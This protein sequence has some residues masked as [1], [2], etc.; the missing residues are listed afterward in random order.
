MIKS[1]IRNFVHDKK[2]QAGYVVRD[3]KKAYGKYEKREN[4]KDKIAHR[5]YPVENK[6]FKREGIYKADSTT[7]KWA[8]ARLKR[9]NYTVQGITLTDKQ[10]GSYVILFSKRITRAAISTT[11]RAGTKTRK[12]RVY[13]AKPG[14]TAT[15]RV[16]MWHGLPLSKIISGVKYSLQSRFDSDE[17]FEAREEAKAYRQDGYKVKLQFIQDQWGEKKYALYTAG[18]RKSRSSY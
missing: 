17:D 10:A 14:K 8:I 4:F 11:R 9:D 5:H 16:Q 1:L 6:G 7:L 18:R 13:T 2:M 15:P 3:A 12:I